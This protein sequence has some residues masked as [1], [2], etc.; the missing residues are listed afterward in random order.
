MTLDA[1]ATLFKLEV[2]V[3]GFETNLCD[4]IVKCPVEK[5][6]TYEGTIVLPIPRIAPIVSLE[7]TFY[8]PES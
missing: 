8:I 5:G 4:G 7:V 3:P 6:K 2:P 1:K